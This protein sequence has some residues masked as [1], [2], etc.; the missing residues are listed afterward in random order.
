[1]TLLQVIDMRG[2][3]GDTDGDGIPEDKDPNI[4]TALTHSIAMVRSTNRNVD[5]RPLTYTL[6]HTHTRT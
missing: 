1:M 4:V 3:D 2:V 6:T 5:R